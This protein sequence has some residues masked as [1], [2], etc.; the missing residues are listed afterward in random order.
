MNKSMHHSVVGLWNSSCHGCQVKCTISLEGHLECG[1][2]QVET[3]LPSCL[4][5]LLSWK[6]KYEMIEMCIK[7]Q[8]GVIGMRMELKVCRRGVRRDSVNLS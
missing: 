8:G 5:L 4:L 6:D 3:Y 1:H 7:P 2:P